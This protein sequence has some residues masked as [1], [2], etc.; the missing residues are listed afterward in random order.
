[1][2]RSKPKTNREVV[3]HYFRSVQ[4]ADPEIGALFSPDVCWVAPQSS[5]VGRRHEG[6]EAV[7]AMMAT[8]IG[9]YDP[10]HPMHIEFESM[11]AE[12]DRVFVEMSLSARTA[13]GAPY[14]NHYVFV[15]RLAEGLIVEIHE[16]FDTHYTQRM[17][18]DPTGQRSPLDVGD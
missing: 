12:G 17:L 10:S 3:E 9:L 16:H 4:T 2:P 7:L 13:A 6:K 11:A 5:P 14:L 15:F 1:M 18:F 8:G